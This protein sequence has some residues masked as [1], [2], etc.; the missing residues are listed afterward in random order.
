LEN[1]T[2]LHF[3]RDWRLLQMDEVQTLSVF[4]EVDL[5]TRHT[6]TSLGIYTCDSYGDHKVTYLQ[7]PKLSTKAEPSLLR[8]PPVALPPQ[9]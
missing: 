5:L 4:P 8:V 9:D 2:L 7:H 3:V 1:L 6:S